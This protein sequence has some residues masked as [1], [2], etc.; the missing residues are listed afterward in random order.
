M[1]IPLDPHSSKAVRER[2]LAYAQRRGIEGAILDDFLFAVGEAVANAIEHSKSK[3]AIE[4]RCSVDEEKILAIVSDGGQGFEY[5]GLTALPL[6]LVERGRGL[7]IM[8][9]FTDIF[10]LQSTPGVGTAVLLGR[11][12]HSF[13]KE[14]SRA[15]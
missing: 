9:G 15:S 1:H 11:Y 6:G 14:S 12:T 8:R 2:L 4:V 13:P 5:A 7:P 10:S 3:T